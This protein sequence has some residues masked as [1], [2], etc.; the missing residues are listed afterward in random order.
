MIKQR[1]NKMAT[2]LC[3]LLQSTPEQVHGCIWSSLYHTVLTSY[4][5]FKH[6]TLVLNRA[7]R[8]SSRHLGTP[9]AILVRLPPSWN[10]CR[11]LARLGHESPMSSLSYSVLCGMSLYKSSSFKDFR[12]VH[13]IC[14]LMKFYFPA[15]YPF[16]AYGP[17]GYPYYGY[18]GGY[19][20]SG[21]ACIGCG[22][23]CDTCYGCGY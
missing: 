20:Y 4:N 22:C 6:W 21:P 1:R 11:H 10:A 17:Y 3:S 13:V 12:P 19:G 5:Y 15:E 16:P 14:K 9:A 7:E 23:G 2:L 8:A 18:Y